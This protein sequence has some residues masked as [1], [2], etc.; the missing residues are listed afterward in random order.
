MSRKAQRRLLRLFSRVPGLYSLQAFA[1]ARRVTV[2]G[3]SMIPTLVP[4]GRLLVD[5][6]AYRRDRPKIGDIVLA[7]P[8]QLPGVKVIKR[9]AAAPT[10]QTLARDEYW[11]L[12]DNPQASTDSKEFGPVKRSDLLGRAW[13]LYW[14]ADR[15]R[16]FD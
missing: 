14:P 4:G 8:R 15:W 9:V 5:R 10:G 12:G 16:V 13:I 3:P 1:C 6:L 11:L 2:R 7:A